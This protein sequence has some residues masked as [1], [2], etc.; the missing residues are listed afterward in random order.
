MTQTVEPAAVGRLT[1]GKRS[2][3]NLPLACHNGDDPQVQEASLEFRLLGPL[4]VF[5]DGEPVALGGR[6]RRAVLAMLVLQRGRVV[7]TDR[8]IAGVW[9][10]EPPETVLTAL[11][12]HVSQLRRVLGEVLVTRAPGYVLE[13]PDARVDVELLELRLEQGRAALAAGDP[14]AASRALD[15]A[16]GLWRG[17]PLDDV[18]DLPFAREARPALEE[19]EVTL[20]EE[21]AEAEL[22]GGRSEEVVPE[23]RALVGQNP[24]RERP[25]AQLM[26]AL[27]RAGRQAEALAAYDDARRTLSEELGIEPGEP[28]RKLHEAIL[29]EDP[30]LGRPA[31]AALPAPRPVELAEHNV[32]VPL[33]AL[34]GRSPELDGI[35]EAL[36]RTRLVTLTGPGGVG[37]TRLA[38][39]VA[40]GQIGRRPDGVWLVDLT[41]GP[42]PAAEV[43]RTLDVGGGSSTAPSELLRGYLADRDLLL[44][45]DNCEHVID[46]CAGLASSLLSSCARLRIL[47]TSREPLGVSGET[48]WRLDSLPAEAGSRL[49]LERARQREHGFMPDAAGSATIAELCER[50][51]RLPLAIELA[52]ARIGVMSPT[53]ILADLE[54]RLGA[55]G[56]GSRLSPARHKTVRAA[57]EWSYEL[58]DATEQRALRNLAVFVGGFDAGAA[59][60]VV[61]GLTVDGLARLVDKSVVASGKTSRGT[62]RYRLLETIREHAHE[63]LSA[64]GEL[65]GTRERH[66][67]HYLAVA[68]Q[69]DPGWPPFVTGALL[70]Q[71]REDY[72]N[73]RAAIEWSAESDPCAGMR[74]LAGSRELFQMLGMADGRRLA[75]LLLPRCE[76]RDRCRVEVLMMAGILAMVIADPEASHAFH[77]D[78][79]RLSSELGDSELEGF[80]MLFRGLMQTLSLAVDP[81][82]ADLE[83]ALTLHRQANNRV[84]EGM[85][86]AALGLT[87]LLT[88]EPDPARELLEQAL[89]IHTA[90]GYPWGEG[91]ARI[92]L[93]TTFEA[94]DPRTASLHYRRALEC[95]QRYR[96][97]VLLPNALIGQAGVIARRDPATALRVTAAAVSV[98]VRAHG[99]FPGFFAARMERIRA[100]CE[101][102]LGTDAARIWAD[103][104]RLGIDQAIALAF[105]DSPPPAPLPPA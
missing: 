23:L 58:L 46:A 79:R 90:A 34:I 56:G 47:A 44:V 81:A 80:A 27:H 7:S 3:P 2:W 76:A 77:S 99:N 8:L 40:R 62:T 9:G 82:R 85:T 98:R 57:V 37:K 84:G 30:A 64:S 92:Y 25:R 13:S 89:A 54:A 17:P 71:R 39:E 97:T 94:T 42:D 72:E 53:E 45:I 43:A 15:E 20:R 16:S 10:D 21:H 66:L 31:A 65:E 73:I 93:A 102:A 83:A 68:E 101:A 88:D 26:L 22:A 100:G 38:T 95:L 29:R 50:L 91:Q 18:A 1:V 49:F 70:D 6:R 55:L 12:G 75:E 63:L 5:R 78:A 96:D 24:L 41:A 60:A 32:P 69:A 51:D 19:L 4:A 48:V 61:G 59:M 28:L 36:R 35:G 105:A 52:A 74:L 87:L 67:H 14:A 104:S 86:L 11:H 33:T 103:G